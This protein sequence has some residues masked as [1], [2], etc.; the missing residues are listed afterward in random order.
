MCGANRNLNRE[1]LETTISLGYFYFQWHRSISDD[2]LGG[3]QASG[4]S[5]QVVYVVVFLR[6]R[7]GKVT[8]RQVDLVVFC[9]WGLWIGPNGRFRF[10]LAVDV[11]RGKVDGAPVQ[12]VAG[13][14]RRWQVDFS[15]AWN[16]TKLSLELWG[17][18]DGGGVEFNFLGGSLTWTVDPQVVCRA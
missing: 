12:R 17:W 15:G 2:R 11:G 16:W 13:R 4:T 5:H 3:F 14:R 7:F 18:V 8:S 9:R 6:G 1:D 10:R